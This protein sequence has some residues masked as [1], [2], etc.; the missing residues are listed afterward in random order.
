MVIGGTVL[1]LLL[2][3][4]IG[5]ERPSVVPHLVNVHTK[6]FPSGHAMLSAVVWLTL[7]A[8]LAEL[9]ARRSLRSYIYGAALTIAILVG[10][11]RVYLGVHYPTD[12]LA[13]W[14]AGLVWALGVWWSARL[15]RRRRVI[16]AESDKIPAGSESASPPSSA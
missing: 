8:M 6:S 7:G 16:E 12:V 13:G 10:I 11:S 3:E 2:K 4:W 14:T 15:L 9:E 1:S 5:R